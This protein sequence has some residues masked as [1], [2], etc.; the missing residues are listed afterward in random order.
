MTTTILFM[1]KTHG[2]KIYFQKIKMEDKEN[3][4]Y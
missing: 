4:I 2:M 1:K 3:D